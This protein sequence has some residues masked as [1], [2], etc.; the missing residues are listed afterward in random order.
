M[1]FREKTAWISLLATLGI[2]GFYFSA[3]ASARGNSAEFFALLIETMITFVVVFVALTIVV[4]ILSPKDADAPADEREKLIG[5]KAERVAYYAVSTGAVAG[6]LAAFCG[7]S[8][9]WIANVLFLTLVV[10]GLAKDAMCI[11]LYRAGV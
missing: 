7:L 4:A 6:M 8:G 1:A 5:L 2:Y 10:A 11:V 9:F 3:L